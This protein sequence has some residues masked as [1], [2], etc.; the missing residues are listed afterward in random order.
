MG[1]KS[2][3]TNYWRAECIGNLHARFWERQLEKC[4]LQGTVVTRWLPTLPHVRCEQGEKVAIT[5]NP[6]LSVLGRRI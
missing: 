3:I 5:S 2:L 1:K 4:Y 6:Y